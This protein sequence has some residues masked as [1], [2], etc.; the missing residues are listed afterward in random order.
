MKA[1]Q[2]I[3]LHFYKKLL[4]YSPTKFD[5][6]ENHKVNVRGIA[7]S[8][9]QLNNGFL[10]ILSLFCFVTLLSCATEAPDGD[11][12]LTSR[13][14]QG[15]PSMAITDNGQLW[16][17]WYAGKTPRE[18]QNNYV[19]VATSSDSGKTWNESFIIDPDNEGPI[20]AYDPELWIDPEGRLWSFWSETIGHD[21][22]IAGVWA[23]VNSNPNKEHSNWSEPIRITDGIMMC[24]PTV[25]SSGEWILPVSTWR[26]TDNSARVIVSTDKGHTFNL[27]G[28]CNVPVEDRNYDEH[29]IV[30]RKDKSLWMLVRTSYG[31]G[32]SASK[33]SGNTWSDLVPS[34]IAHPSA[35]FF[36]RHL[37]SGNLL[38]VKHGPINER[39]GRSHL[40]AY[41]SED[42]GYSWLGG[43]L[44]DERD[45]VSYPDGQQREDGTI[46]IVY[47]YSRTGA[48]EILMA[49][50]TE[51]DVI[52][53]NQL[54]A[55]VSLRMIVSKF[56]EFGFDSKKIF[57]D[58]AT[59][60]FTTQRNGSEI[61]YTIDGTEPKQN[62]LLYTGPFVISKT[63][64][65]TVREF[66]SDGLI[67]PV[68]EANYIKEKPIKSL[69]VIPKGGGLNFKYF[70]LTEPIDSLAD[71]QK[72]EPTETGEVERFIFPYKDENL[73]ENFGLSFSGYI[74]VPKDD[75][76]IFSLLSNDGSRLFIADK[77]VVDNDGPH[78]TT[79]KGGEI[80]LQKGWHKIEL[81][82][83]QAGGGKALQ[84]FVESGGAEKTELKANTLKLEL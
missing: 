7:L 4:Q 64:R 65:L 25:L 10:K 45:G 5:K 34:A 83:F 60:K 82:Y 67:L 53:G 9:E 58:K 66:T 46:H 37:Q 84:V 18:D 12:K 50:F 26:D 52:A 3:G 24:K 77:L 20:R 63:T 36:I 49:T 55:T 30:E 31:I 38:L 29:M 79:E 8:V 14:F 74:E 23:K 78:G 33:D 73:S 51:E 59:V 19:V 81:L 40:T 27:R 28:A 72:Y 61:R 35:R 44:L 80:A 70:R 75:V 1:G 71:L 13:K 54:S 39:I 57:I 76:Y 42:D 56:L 15:I 62:S 43:L 2:L 11:H 22:T 47:D 41:I 17:T 48:R 68:Y 6:L 69:S 16:A 21:G 32:E